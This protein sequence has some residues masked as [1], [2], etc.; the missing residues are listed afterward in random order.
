MLAPDSFKKAVRDPSAAIQYLWKQ[1]RNEV[2]RWT[3]HEVG[4]QGSYETGNIGDRALG[5]QFKSQF[6]QEGYQTSLF[7]KQTTSSNAPTRILGGGGVL[8]DWY[9]T[10][11]LENRLNYVSSGEKKMILGVGAPGF[12]SKKAQSLASK[13]LPKMDAITVRDEWSKS[14]IEAVCDVEP[15]VTAC[16]VFL[17]KD[18]KVKTT[19][20]TGVNFRP[21]FDEK[22]DISNS[23][24]K[25]YFGYDD[26]EGATKA[27][28]NNARL[29]CQRV[30]NPVF[31]PFTP[32]DEEFAREFLD[33]PVHSYEF[34]VQQ[35]L[36]RVSEVERMVATR[37]HSLIFAAICGKPVLP[38]AYEPKVEE[39]AERLDIDYYKPHKEIDVEFA[40]VSNI[41]Q[42]RAAALENFEIAFQTIT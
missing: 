26:I 25:D 32:R 28:I 3:P 33:I 19:E 13:V 20:R 5:E 36:K 30:E 27:Y 35:T 39:V 23:V 9:G 12:Q 37:Y 17:Y 22:D 40:E 10:K 15:T 11:H 4:V 42:L 2:R 16:P 6:Q 1:S 14:N 41:K 24:L 34:S 31:I 18:P 29:I 21:Y 38:I 7:G 8:H